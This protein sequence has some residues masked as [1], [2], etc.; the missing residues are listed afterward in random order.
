MLDGMADR[1]RAAARAV[2]DSREAYDAA[3]ELRDALIVE[4]IDQGMQQ[5][6]VAALTGVSRSR[7]IA[8]LGVSELN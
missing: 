4:A 1:L 3:R 7:V 8:I 6:A 2:V 5:K